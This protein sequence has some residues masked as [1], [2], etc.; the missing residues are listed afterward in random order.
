SALNHP[1][2][3]FA[4][5]Q[6]V[7]SLNLEYKLPVVFFDEIDSDI[8][9]AKIYPKLLAPMWDGRFY[10]GKEKFLLGPAVFF[11]AGSG[12]SCEPESKRILEKVQRTIRYNV[13]F[14]KWL[15]EFRKYVNRHQPEKLPDFIDRIDNIL[16]IPPISRKFLGP[17]TMRELEDIICMLIQKHFEDDAEYI[18]LD[19]LKQLSGR[20]REPNAI[21]E[22]EKLIFGSSRPSD[23]HFDIYHLPSPDGVGHPARTTK[24]EQNYIQIIIRK[25]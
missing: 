21:R 13:Y 4:M 1:D 8:A 15:K 19:L 9:G 11:F 18:G 16:R 3:L 20:L 24:F 12:L 14:A 2:E 17:Q 7:Q 6:R 5:F 25:S 10:I 23:K 22:V